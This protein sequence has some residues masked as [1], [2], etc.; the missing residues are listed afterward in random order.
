MCV[1]ALVYIFLCPSHTTP[2]HSHTLTH[3]HTHRFQKIETAMAGMENKITQ[4]KESLQ[5]LK[6]K[7]GIETLFKKVVA[8]G[9]KRR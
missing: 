5:T 8:Q 9:Q 1:S 7:P 2:H 4:H 6:P 3:T